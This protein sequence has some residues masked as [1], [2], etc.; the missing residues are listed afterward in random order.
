MRI[1]YRNGN[2]FYIVS[3]TK[4]HVLYGRY[5]PN[6]ENKTAQAIIVR[7][8]YDMLI[9]KKIIVEEFA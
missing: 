2:A 5:I 9:D 3:K 6:H 1:F 7:A 8:Y 4:N